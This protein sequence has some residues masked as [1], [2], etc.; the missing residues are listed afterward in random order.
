MSDHIRMPVVSRS[1]PPRQEKPDNGSFSFPIQSTADLCSYCKHRIELINW[2]LNRHKNPDS[3]IDSLPWRT[4]NGGKNPTENFCLYE[5]H[6]PQRRQPHSDPWCDPEAAPLSM[7]LHRARMCVLRRLPPL[8][9]DVLLVPHRP[10]R[11][12]SE[13]LRDLRRKNKNNGVSE[14]SSCIN[15][16][17]TSH[18][19]ITIGF[20]GWW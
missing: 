16:S 8:V 15:F 5:M 7:R 3:G 19:S 2:I 6:Q 12:Y 1:E 10:F 14:R 13:F 20:A 9:L 4:Y 11:C 17:Q 18:E